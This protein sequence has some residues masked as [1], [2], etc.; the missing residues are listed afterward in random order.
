MK[1]QKPKVKFTYHMIDPSVIPAEVRRH[2]EILLLICQAITLQTFS[3]LSQGHCL[4]RE[5]RFDQMD[6]IQTQIAETIFYNSDICDFVHVNGSVMPWA[7]DSMTRFLAGIPFS[8][9]AIPYEE[10]EQVQ[11]AAPHDQITEEMHQ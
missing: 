10:D 5:E 1:T 11:H 6:D 8:V 2:I 9:D 3:S 4:S 7:F